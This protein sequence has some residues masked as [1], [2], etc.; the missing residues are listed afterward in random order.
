MEEKKIYKIL[1][2]LPLFPHVYRR[3]AFDSL[4]Q[5]LRLMQRVFRSG[6]RISDIQLRRG[7]NELTCPGGISGYL[8]IEHLL[9]CY[10]MSS[11]FFDDEDESQRAFSRVKIKK[12]K[13]I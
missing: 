11:V 1:F 7:R 9:D 8:R 13:Q 12:S 10:E 3:I 6:D 5:D 2:Y 4:H